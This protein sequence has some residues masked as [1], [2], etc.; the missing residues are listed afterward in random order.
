M[1]ETIKNLVRGLGGLAWLGIVGIFH[2]RDKQ[3]I[4]FGCTAC[5]PIG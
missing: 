3:F 5:S 4:P 1:E 2:A